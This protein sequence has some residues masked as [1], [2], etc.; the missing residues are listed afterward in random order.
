MTGP[1]GG[2]VALDAA[3]WHHLTPGIGVGCATVGVLAV[4]LV[5]LGYGRRDRAPAPV[6]GLALAGAA[7]VSLRTVGVA[8]SATDRLCLGVALLAIGPTVVTL[9]TGPTTGPGVGARRTLL[10]AA[11]AVPGALVVADAAT[12]VS[13]HGWVR[14]L[15]LVTT[16]VGGGAVAHTDDRVGPSGVALVALVAAVGAAFTTLPDTEQIGAI[17]G[18]AV[19]FALLGFPFAVARVGP[20]SFAVAGLLA[21][22]AAVEGAGR[23]GAALGPVAGLG[24]LWAVPL[25]DL[26]WRGHL[27]LPTRP[28]SMRA[29][30]LLG[31]QAIVVTVT[32]RVAGLRTSLTA[33]GAVAGP[34]LVLTGI[35]VVALLAPDRRATPGT[36]TSRSM[37]GDESSR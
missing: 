17:A 30:L 13:P 21:W 36:A 20:G 32:A 37:G 16:V 19:G 14:P 29:V 18:V 12:R 22:A 6:A 27:H 9:L 35:A 1:L 10:A 26:V 4:V 33:A 15:V 25:A 2:V 34:V 7:L 31:L 8:T 3:V 28:R 24:V 23:P 11:C 5:A